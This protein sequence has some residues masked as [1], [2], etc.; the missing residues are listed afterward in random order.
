M[1]WIPITPL[2]LALT[3]RP[4]ANYQILLQFF[5]LCER[6]HGGPGFVL[7]QTRNRDSV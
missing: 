5:G 7:H 2:L 1:R 4:S 3:W 6:G